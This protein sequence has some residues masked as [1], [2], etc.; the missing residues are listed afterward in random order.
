M[1]GTAIMGRLS[2][3]STRH[4]DNSSRMNRKFLHLPLSLSGQG[5]GKWILRDIYGITL[6]DKAREKWGLV[7]RSDSYS[8]G[9]NISYL[10][11]IGDV[12]V[13]D[14]FF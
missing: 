8:M 9:E 5:L 11:P 3:L 2:P 13:I 12:D 6:E 7:Y 1:T 14:F 10:T 4:G